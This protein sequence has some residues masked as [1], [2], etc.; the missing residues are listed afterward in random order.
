MV[1]DSRP[2]TDRGRRNRVTLVFAA[3]AVITTLSTLVLGIGSILIPIVF[4]AVL[5]LWWGWWIWRNGIWAAYLRT[6]P[7]RVVTASMP[8]DS[9]IRNG[10]APKGGAQ[11]SLSKRVWDAL[12]DHGS[13]VVRPS[14]D[15][16]AGYLVED[17]DDGVIIRWGFR[18]RAELLLIPDPRL[19]ACAEI[20]VSTGFHVEEEEDA[21]GPYLRVTQDLSGVAGRPLDE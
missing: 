9:P 2:R 17:R 1:Q 8:T 14:T 20:L 3:I 7:R 15:A 10:V 13:P 11:V 16:L 12:L 18:K 5:L 21:L 19:Q 4:F 6:H